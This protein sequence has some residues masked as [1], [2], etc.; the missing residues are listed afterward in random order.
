MPSIEPKYPLTQLSEART[1]VGRN[2]EA[3]QE[4]FWMRQVSRV[5]GTD[6]LLHIVGHV[7]PSQVAKTVAEVRSQLP[8]GA[9][10]TDIAQELTRRKALLCGGLGLAAGLL[11]PGVNL[12]AG[13]A[14]A[15]VNI[16]FQ[17]ELV[18]EIACAY[19]LDLHSPDRKGEAL[20]VLAAGLGA[21]QATTTSLQFAQRFAVEKLSEAAI[22]QL[23]R[24]LSL[25]IAEQVVLRGIPLVG[26]CAGAG[27]NAGFVTLVGNAAQRF[28]G[29]SSR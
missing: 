29:N 15:F 14:D 24:L 26:A 23:A 16:R 9:T 12:A 18:Y 4:S 2:I 8:T 11:P 22:A 19:D 28:Y 27:M 7:N 5:L 21:E 17:V 3:I 13:L 6:W 20:M 10:A 25:Q 1:F